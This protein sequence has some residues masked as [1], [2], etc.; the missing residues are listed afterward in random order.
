MIHKE[1]LQQA[2]GNIQVIRFRITKKEHMKKSVVL[3]ICFLLGLLINCHNA[4]ITAPTDEASILKLIP[5]E[6]QV[7]VRK[8]LNK[9]GENKKALLDALSKTP[10]GQRPAMGFLIGMTGYRYFMPTITEKTCDAGVISS[11]LLLNNV[12]LGYEARKKFPWAQE[13]DKDM[14]RR[15]VLT[16]RM[17]TEKLTDWRIYFW[18]NEE[19]QG[20]FN[21]YLKLI[22]NSYVSPV[23]SGIKTA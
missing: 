20:L 23:T 19:L 4:G 11:T 22:K 14:F 2:T 15:Y 1:T 7:K 13:L 8:S 9:A 12:K 3:S 17:T 10:E 18:N 5:S 6:Y 16:Y 21:E